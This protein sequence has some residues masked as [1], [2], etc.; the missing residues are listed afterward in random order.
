MPPLEIRATNPQI[1]RREFLKLS[2]AA[3]ATA[4]LPACFPDRTKT[5]P[6]EIIPT[7]DPLDTLLDQKLLPDYLEPT[8]ENLPEIIDRMVRVVDAAL[9]RLR[10]IDPSIH[11][12]E[13]M[14]EEI[15]QQYINTVISPKFNTLVKNDKLDTGWLILPEVRDSGM[16]L[17]I[18]GFQPVIS[19]DWSEKATGLD[20]IELYLGISLKRNPSIGSQFEEVELDENGIYDEQN[21]LTPGLSIY[22][23]KTS[24]SIHSLNDAAIPLLA[25]AIRYNT[26]GQNFPKDSYA[27]NSDISDALAQVIIGQITPQE[28]YSYYRTN[29][30][31]NFILDLLP[32]EAESPLGPKELTRAYVRLNGLLSQ[33]ETGQLK[34]NDVV[35]EFSKYIKE[36]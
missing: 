33:V 31:Y 14:T 4:F 21:T 17:S 1:S 7:P 24:N 22:N 28:L 19:R 13:E 12:S 36:L 3:A 35:N 29:D 10:K 6:P 32:G 30:P 15:R 27:E 26:D 23:L 5:S 11:A 20:A 34:P 8:D 25:R 9:P 18:I 2:S 16:G